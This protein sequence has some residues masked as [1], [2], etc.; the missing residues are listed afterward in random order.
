[1]TVWRCGDASV[2]IAEVDFDGVLIVDHTP[3]V[4]DD[5]YRAILDG[6]VGKPALHN[7][8]AGAGISRDGL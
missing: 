4:I 8:K 6:Q 5:A 2:T 3:H 7:L 1:M